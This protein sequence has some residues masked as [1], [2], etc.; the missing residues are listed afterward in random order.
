MPGGGAKVRDLALRLPGFRLFGLDFAIA[1]GETLVILGPNGAGK[2]VCL[3][4]IA[5]FHRLERGE[6]VLGGRDVAALPPERRNI[7]LVFQNFG[8]FPHLTVAGNVRL[9]ISARRGARR[10]LGEL[11]AEFEIAHLAGRFPASLSPGEKQRVALARALAAQPDLFLFDEPFS[12][13]DAA[14]RERLRAELGSFLRE[15]AIPALF[16]THDFADALALADRVAVMRAGRIVQEGPAP[17]VF[18][19]PADR[20]VAEFFGIENILCGRRE[21]AR[22]VRV[23]SA[24][25]E[26]PADEAAPGSS[27]VL[28]CVR[29]EEVELGSKGTRNGLDA[30][31]LAIR[32]E[33][34]LVRLALD[35]GF[36]LVARTMSRDLERLGLAAGANVV[37]TVPPRAIHLIPLD[38]ASEGRGQ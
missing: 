33:G 14:T 8:L 10:R 23:G 16:V 35:C 4:A 30:R 34:V 27:L 11:L 20:F 32:N 5:G 36:P 29:A 15:A 9:A 18:R 22:A 37:V 13:L 38:G 17:Q 1:P 7:A 26:V 2:S 3:E 6:I 21:A 25:L 24:S 28:L 31:I 19:A 12:A